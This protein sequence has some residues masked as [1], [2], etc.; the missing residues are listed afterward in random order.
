[1]LRNLVSLELPVVER[2]ESLYAN[3]QEAQLVKGIHT[4]L[5]EGTPALQFPCEIEA[6][7][8]RQAI[9]NYLQLP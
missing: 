2:F 1:M 9:Q 8:M 4:L 5:G 3:R 6:L 7:I